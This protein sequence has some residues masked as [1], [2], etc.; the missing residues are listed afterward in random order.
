MPG[1]IPIWRGSHMA[2]TEVP[3]SKEREAMYA[4]VMEDK[5]VT[6]ILGWTEPNSD[7]PCDEN[8]YRER[9]EKNAAALNQKIAEALRFE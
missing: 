4:D 8:A 6:I 7:A 2:T 9:L 3:S 1:K 5:A